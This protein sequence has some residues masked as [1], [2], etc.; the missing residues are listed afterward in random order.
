MSNE[1]AQKIISAQQRIMKMEAESKQVKTNLEELE[2]E[3]LEELD[4]KSMKDAEKKYEGLKKEVKRD[5]LKL[6]EKKRK[7][8][9]KIRDFQR[10]VM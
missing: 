5:D 6:E 8:D 1:Q 4:A 3:L 7:L 2:V 9:D 10:R